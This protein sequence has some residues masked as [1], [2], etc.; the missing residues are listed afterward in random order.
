MNNKQKNSLE[1]SN[2]QL[3]QFSDDSLLEVLPEK[4]EE[5]NA[6][7]YVLIKHDY[8]STDSEHGRKLLSG[9]FTSLANSSFNSIVIYLIDKGVK[10]L[11]ETNPL[12]EDFT[13][14]IGKTELLIACED[15]INAYNITVPDNLVFTKQSLFSMTEEIIYLPDYLVLE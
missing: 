6:T 11:D 13:E 12:H 7:K 1:Y 9:F 2:S 15:S 14:L 5:D 3:E 4:N 10:L 8:Y